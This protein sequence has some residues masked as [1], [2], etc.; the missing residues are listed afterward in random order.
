MLV[1]FELKQIG[2]FLLVENGMFGF[3]IK[4]EVQWEL[5]FEYNWN[6]YKVI[7]ILEWKID[8][9]FFVGDFQIGVLCI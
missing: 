9:C 5:V 1:V 2:D 7:G 4:D 8:F 3:C 6:N